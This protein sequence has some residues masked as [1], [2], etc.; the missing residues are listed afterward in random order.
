MLKKRYI[1]KGRY[2]RIIGGAEE[3]DKT[4]GNAFGYQ[5]GTT[6]YGCF[7]KNSFSV[8]FDGV[9]RNKKLCGNFFVL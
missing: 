8:V 3:S 4:F 1:Q 6:I 5:L 7:F 9:E 2:K